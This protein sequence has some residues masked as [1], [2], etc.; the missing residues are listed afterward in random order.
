M[1][2]VRKA[3]DY[4]DKETLPGKI[5]DNFNIKEYKKCFLA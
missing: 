5:F 3:L 1:E 2:S 4:V